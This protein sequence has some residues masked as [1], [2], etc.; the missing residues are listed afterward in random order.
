MRNKRVKEEKID[1]FLNG[2]ELANKQR[3]GGEQ[4]EGDGNLLRGCGRVR[5]I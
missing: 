4:W 3:Q 2:F 5:Q 1:G